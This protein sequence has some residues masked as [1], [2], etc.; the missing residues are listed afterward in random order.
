MRNHINI[1]YPFSGYPHG[2]QH[3]YHGGKA[4]GRTQRINPGS[5]SGTQVG[6]QDNDHGNATG[7]KLGD[8][9]NPI[10]AELGNLSDHLA[11]PKVRV[12]N[13][14]IE[15]NQDDG[16][17]N[18]KNEQIMGNLSSSYAGNGVNEALNNPK[19]SYDGNQ[20]GVKIDHTSS[21]YL[22]SL[23]EKLVL[24]RSISQPKC[25]EG[26]TVPKNF[27]SAANGR[28]LVLEKDLPTSERGAICLE[29]DQPDEH[30]QR[31]TS[32]YVDYPNRVEW[33]EVNYDGNGSGAQK[34]YHRCDDDFID[35]E[36]SGMEDYF[37]EHNI[38]HEIIFLD[39]HDG[40]SNG[41]IINLL[42]IHKMKHR[43]RSLPFVTTN[44][45][46][47]CGGKHIY[48]KGN[49]GLRFGMP[50][51]DNMGRN[52]KSWRKLSPRGPMVFCVNASRTSRAM[53]SMT[54]VHYAREIGEKSRFVGNLVCQFD[55]V[56]KSESRGVAQVIGIRSS[57][58][59]KEYTF[60][61]LIHLTHRRQDSNY[62]N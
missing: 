20:L 27:P 5:V 32:H 39:D 59:D 41:Y 56:C 19:A 47:A 23:G 16:S 42:F 6:I 38:S 9:G 43:G 28:A 24:S 22:A 30:G 57:R 1:R 17:C 45:S 7:A 4:F 25:K 54:N 62:H 11:R 53:R 15:M 12:Q 14:G 8:N 3:E 35:G 33:G 48:H 36:D 2:V 60:L 40:I 52:L 50:W 37:D 21:S 26:V 49:D 51:G 31:A 18:I 10:E 13:D 61:W 29:K 46:E 58:L 44:S 34:G 55:L